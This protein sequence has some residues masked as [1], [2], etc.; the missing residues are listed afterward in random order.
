MENE[1]LVALIQSGVDIAE[2][3]LR[4]WQQNKGLIGKIALKYSA[5]EDIEDLKQQGYIG[6]CN[7]AESYRMDEGTKFSTYAVC[8][9]RQSMERYIETYGSCVR[10]PSNQQQKIRKLRQ[11]EGQYLKMMGREPTEREMCRLLD[12]NM[13]QLQQ[14]RGDAIKKDVKSLDTPLGEDAEISLGECIM[15]QRDNYAA[16][17]DDIQQEELR[18]VLWPLVDSLGERSAKVLRSRYKEGRTLKETG[19]L[20]GCCMQRAQSIERAALRTLR[21][22][23]Y[24]KQLRPFLPETVKAQAYRHN[25]VKEFN[26]TWTSSTERAALQWELD[27]ATLQEQVD[28]VYRSSTLGEISDGN[29]S[30]NMI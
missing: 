1:Q 18:T 21:R 13:K 3:M 16:V 4:L 30:E 8:W 2:N 24:A 7:A 20:L 15:D 22:P 6:L 12:M 11:I 9:I 5:F 19:E 17:L 23:R 14:L 10:L 29:Q 27:F 28:T 25:G 26:R